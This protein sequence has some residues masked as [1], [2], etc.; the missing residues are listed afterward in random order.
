MTAARGAVATLEAVA[1]PLQGND[2]EIQITTCAEDSNV[3]TA[4]P[5]RA[6]GDTIAAA[7]EGE[8]IDKSRITVTSDANPADPA[9]DADEATITVVNQERVARTVAHTL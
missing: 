6:L 2:T 9:V 8:G 3:V 7:L 1:V 4:E 5:R